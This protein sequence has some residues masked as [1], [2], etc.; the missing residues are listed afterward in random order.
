M[1]DIKTQVEPR[2]KVR[3]GVIG[4]A[5]LG[6]IALGG[7]LAAAATTG[8]TSAEPEQSARH[9]LRE[10]VEI[11]V[12][13][14]IPVGDSRATG[15][16]A[17]VVVGYVDTRIVLPTETKVAKEYCTKP[18]PVVNAAGTVVG[19]FF[20]DYG[21]VRK[22]DARAPGFSIRAERERQAG[23]KD[24]PSTCSPTAEQEAREVARTGG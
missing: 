3:L 6:A 9:D 12:E 21:F 17:D 8:G 24:L 16:A 19:Y 13:F 23:T 15:P 18:A 2:S 14:R 1:N 20:R 5:V 7:G 4:M 10:R 22:D 11:P